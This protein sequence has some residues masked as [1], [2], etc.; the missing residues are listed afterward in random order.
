[1]DLRIVTT[2]KQ[3]NNLKIIFEA[4]GKTPKEYPSRYDKNEI[5]YYIKLEDD[6]IELIAE[7]LKS[8]DFNTGE[9]LL[10]NN[11]DKKELPE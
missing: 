5:R 1:M 11:N 2:K 6:I 3:Q 9:F 10:N 7:K 8:I 4:L